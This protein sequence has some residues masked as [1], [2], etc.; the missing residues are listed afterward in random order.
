MACTQATRLGG[1]I[2]DSMVIVLLSQGLYI[3][4]GLYNEVGPLPGSLPCLLLN[5]SCSPPFLQL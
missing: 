4:D 3:M 5:A 1:R 2:T